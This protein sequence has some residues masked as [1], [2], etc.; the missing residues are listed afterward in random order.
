MATLIKIFQ[1]L[2]RRERW[3][4][5][6]IFVLI[7]LMAI[8]EMAGVASIMPFVAVV[9][10]PKLVG[11]NLYLSTLYNYFGFSS[12]HN[13]LFLL[14][15]AVFVFLLVS[16]AFKA[17]TTW[18]LLRFTHMREYS[19]GVR[20]V[21]GYLW[22]PYEWFLGRHSADLGKAVLSE[23]QEVVNGALIPMMQ[24]LAQGAVVLALLLLLIVAD[25]MLALGIGGV[26]GLGYG[27]LYALLR[28][29]IMLMGIEREVA[30]NDRFKSLAEAFGGV[31]EVKVGG[32]EDILIRRYNGPAK[33]VAKSITAA[34]LAKQMPRFVLEALAFG[35][36]LLVVLYLMRTHGRLDQAMPIIALYALG[37]YKLLP[38]LQQV[39]VHLS[40]LRFAQPALEKLHTDLI[41]MSSL[42]MS[43]SLA[44]EAMTVTREIRLKAVSYHYPGNERLALNG[45]DLIIPAHAT[46][47]LVG[48]T[49]SGKTTAVDILLGLLAPTVGVLEVDGRPVH[50]GNCRDW[51]RV[52]GYVPQQI[53]LIDDSI[54][55]NI[56]FGVAP[57]AVD[58]TAVEYAARV[59]NLH[60]F[61]IHEL[62]AGYATQ[63]GE[64]GVRL[65]GGQRQRIGIARA[66]Y[67]G[68]RVLVLDE[69]TSAL[70]NLTEQAVMEAVHNL[71]HE[72][73]IIMIAHR[74]S[75]VRECDC[76]YVLDRGLVSA[77]GTYDEL[78]ASSDH[79]RRL[80]EVAAEG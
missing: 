66:L 36:M 44:T 40:T 67:H 37:S 79:F 69:A 22:Q 59:A 49:G 14:G 25:P 41:S 2:T 70:D 75:T 35:G 80:A 34:Q 58:H 33:Q 46:V 30:N 72:I 62:P 52:L 45:L 55:A 48:P 68:P 11:T 74:L 27:V 32:L 18:A 23:V 15:V 78:L 64:R 60:D 54:T 65:S 43:P 31:K 29:R 61:I 28:R 16:I 50:E 71:D 39:Y 73:T 3:Q 8:L 24:M 9:A 42:E 7:I 26:L 63:V 12:I 10:D 1:I 21:S 53:F 17:L 56:A 5:L 47:G 13:F 51:Q 4:A 38:A 19:L 76:I 77:Q 20:L 57:E 6:G